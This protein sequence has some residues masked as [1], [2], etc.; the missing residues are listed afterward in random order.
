[1]SWAVGLSF[2]RNMFRTL[3]PR[4]FGN[5]VALGQLWDQ[6]RLLPATMGRTVCLS[7]KTHKVSAS[8]SSR[9]TGGRTLRQRRTKRRVVFVVL[10]NVNLNVVVLVLMMIAIV[11][12]RMGVRR[13]GRRRDGIV[14]ILIGVTVSRRRSGSRASARAS[15]SSGSNVMS[16]I[17]MLVTKSVFIQ[18]G[19]PRARLFGFRN[20][21]ASR[22]RG[23]RALLFHRE[24]RK[25]SRKS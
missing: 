2:D 18:V 17:R 14:V 7:S 12:V 13:G 4:V 5:R 15:A 9:T 22:G 11:V 1:M 24:V 19:R 3:F 25:I 23:C 16:L 6:R 21:S 8:R 20:A 10:I